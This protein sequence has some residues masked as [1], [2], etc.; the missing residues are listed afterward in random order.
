MNQ[1]SDYQHL[2]LVY[3][4]KSDIRM[5]IDFTEV[6]MVCGQLKMDPQPIGA[7]RYMSSGITPAGTTTGF[8]S[9]DEL[10][11]FP[12]ALPSSQIRELQQVY[13]NKLCE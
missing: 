13:E 5:Y 7:P 11:V 10:L 9:I 12:D 6:E 4:G 3:N 2:A 1:T 8:G